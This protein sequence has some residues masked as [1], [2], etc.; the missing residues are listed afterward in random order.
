M[1]TTPA[2]SKVEQI[3]AALDRRGSGSAVGTAGPAAPVSTK[4]LLE[5]AMTEAEKGGWRRA[6]D[7]V[8]RAK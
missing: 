8:K 2:R 3:Q 7:M 4:A 5:D 1:A 6:M